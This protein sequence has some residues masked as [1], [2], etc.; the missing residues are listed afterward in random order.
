VRRR[1]IPD[2]LVAPP[3][4][5]SWTRLWGS[6]HPDYGGEG[7]TSIERPDGWVIPGESAWVLAAQ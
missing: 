5:R 4:G 3:A 6:E 2:P 1:S 7:L